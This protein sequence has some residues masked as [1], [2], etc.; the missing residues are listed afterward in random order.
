[1]KD[2]FHLDPVDGE[3]LEIGKAGKTR[4]EIIEHH[5]YVAPAQFLRHRADLLRKAHED[6]FGDL[7]F[8]ARRV[9]AGGAQNVVE[10]GEE[11]EVKQVVGADV[12]RQ[13]E[14]RNRPDFIAGAPQD[15][16]AQLLVQPDAFGNRHELARRYRAKLGMRPPRQCLDPDDAVGVA[17]DERLVEDLDLSRL[18]RLAQ[19][20]F[21][22]AEALRGSGKFA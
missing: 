11:V 10:I 21:Q 12:D 9:K 20:G 7:D 15:D 1:M 16:I 4:A 13:D 2:E 14:V 17:V 19:T 22:Y 6:A 18:Q 3:V 8:E 5:R